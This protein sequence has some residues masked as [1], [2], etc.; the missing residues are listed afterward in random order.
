MRFTH[1]DGREVTVEV[2]IPGEEVTTELVLDT[3]WASKSLKVSG[4]T[5]LASRVGAALLDGERVQIGEPWVYVHISP[6]RPDYAAIAAAI[7]VGLTPDMSTLTDEQR[8]MVAG[9]DMDARHRAVT[10]RPGRRICF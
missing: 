8:H 6:Y 2:L 10:E 4:D 1:A 3:E 9:M 5:Q 7:C